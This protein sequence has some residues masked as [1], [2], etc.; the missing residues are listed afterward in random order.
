MIPKFGVENDNIEEY[1]LSLLPSFTSEVEA[2]FLKPKPR[3][4]FLSFPS[5]FFLVLGVDLREK[6]E[7]EKESRRL[8]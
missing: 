5:F 8:L 6:K 2:P 1:E 7:K 3:S 4:I